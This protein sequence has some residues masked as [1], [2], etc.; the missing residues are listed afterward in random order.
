VAEAAVVLGVR[1]EHV[2]VSDD[3][4]FSGTVALIEPMGNH[5]VV[6]LACGAL[7]LAAIVNDNRVLALGQPLR[8]TIDTARVSVFDKASEQR[9]DALH[10]DQSLRAMRH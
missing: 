5:Q 6:W 4:Q 3:G 8:F 10:G 7:Q 1:P 9:L 2:S